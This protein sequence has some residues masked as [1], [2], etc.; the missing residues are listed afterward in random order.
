LNLNLNAIFNGFVYGCTIVKAYN[1]LQILFRNYLSPAVPGFQIAFSVLI[2]TTLLTIIP[3]FHGTLAPKAIVY[4]TDNDSSRAIQTAQLTR[5]YNSGL[6]T[7][8]K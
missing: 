7:L 2:L 8:R 6:G 4:S 1:F 5:W 3:V